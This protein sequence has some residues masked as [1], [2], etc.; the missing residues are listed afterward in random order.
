VDYGR[1]QRINGTMIDI[2]YHIVY[3]TCDE[4]N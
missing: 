4:D 2:L 1:L 3:T